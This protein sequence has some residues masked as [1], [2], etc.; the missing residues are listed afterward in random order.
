MF[1]FVPFS[2]KTGLIKI[3][4]PQQTSP[5]FLTGNYFL[6]VLRVKRALR[7]LNV[8]LLVAD[9]HGINVWCAAKG[10]H[11]TDYAV[12]SALKMSG[13]DKLVEHR[14]V[15]L[16]QLAAAG[17]QAAVVKKKSGW[18]VLWGPV[19]AEDIPLYIEQNFKK[20][21]EM[22][23]VKFPLSARLEMSV[24]WAFPVSMV[25]A[26]LALIFWRDRWIPL[27]VSVWGMSL[28]VF[29]T[30]PLFFPLLKTDNLGQRFRTG[31]FGSFLYRS[32]LYFGALAGIGLY[33]LLFE[34]FDSGCLLSWGIVILVL[35]LIL[36][37]DLKGSTP[38]L[39]SETHEEKRYKVVLDREKC[40]GAAFC[41]D[42]CPQD[43]FFFGKADK[44]VSFS[45]S[46]RCVRCGACI[47]QC[48]FDALFFQDRNGCKIP[49]EN[50]RKYKLDLRGKRRIKMI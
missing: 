10:G 33:C 38:V 13:V 46:G 25:A 9:S 11:F 40:K 17:I 49:P 16:P 26:F 4:N 8:Y 42:V 12:L 27:V 30:F 23:R 1:R 22:R 32:I 37:L 39:K 24:A 15:I 31:R 21:T 48:P 44:K 45:G 6:T 43:C 14:K 3:G 29:V 18:R 28:L 34:E 50:I 5:V 47:V 20:T 36:T 35:V 41:E 19:Y 2:H 7:G